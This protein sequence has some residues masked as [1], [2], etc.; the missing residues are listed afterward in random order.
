MNKV[1]VIRGSDGAVEP[2]NY[3]CRLVRNGPWVP[4]R[5]RETADGYEFTVDG[6]IVEDY[7]AEFPQGLFGILEEEHTE[8]AKA[9]ATK[10]LQRKIKRQLK[11]P[12]EPVNRLT[13]KLPF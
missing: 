1:W 4:V 12:A 5:V 9:D 8:R 11:A 7:M 6:R 10:D 13:V 3:R 2:G